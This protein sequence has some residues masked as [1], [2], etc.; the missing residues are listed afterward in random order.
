MTVQPRNRIVIFRL[1]QDEYRA[2][3][4]VCERCGGRSLS[5]FTRS[6]VLEYLKTSTLPDRPHLSVAA[7][8][9]EV[10]GLKDA[11]THLNRLVAKNSLRRSLSPLT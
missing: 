4:E 6:E 9:Q 5:E 1:S 10:A 2:L 3:N 7:L 11:V 8:E